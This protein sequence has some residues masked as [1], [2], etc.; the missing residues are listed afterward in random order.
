MPRRNDVIAEA[1]RWVG[2]AEGPR[3]NETVFGARTGYQFQPWC[4]SFTDCVLIDSGFNVSKTGSGNTEPSSVYTPSGINSYKRLGRYMDANGPCEPGDIV[5]FDFERNGVVDHVGIVT[6]SRGVYVDTIE[7][8]TSLTNQANG[9]QVMVR[10]RHRFVIAGFGRPLYTSESGLKPNQ[11]FNHTEVDMYIAVDGVGFFA[12]VGMVT[13]PLPG[14]D[15]VGFA[16]LME[17]G[18]SVGFITIPKSAAQ[19]FVAKALKQTAK[20]TS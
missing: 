5:Y 9:G 20:A 19:D 13:V 1:K 12:Q 18:K 10:A 2:Y 7:G 16:K 15:L 6:G 14:L 11:N 4:G 8:N 17:A 3:N